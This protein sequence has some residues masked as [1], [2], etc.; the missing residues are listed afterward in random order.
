[1][2]AIE[3]DG[4]KAWPLVADASDELSVVAMIDHAIDLLGALDALSLNVGIA[5]GHHLADTTVDDWDRVMTTN[6]RSA[7]LGVNTLFPAWPT[8]AASS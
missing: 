7:F 5:S 2:A 8:V 1:M 4:G 3:L 6:V